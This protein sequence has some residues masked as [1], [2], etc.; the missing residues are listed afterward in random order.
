MISHRSRSGGEAA[1]K[2]WRGGVEGIF[3]AEEQD[4]DNPIGRFR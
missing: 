3:H 4:D 1:E 2:R